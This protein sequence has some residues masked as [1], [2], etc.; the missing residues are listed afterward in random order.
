MIVIFERL[1]DKMHAVLEKEDGST[2]SVLIDKL[3]KDVKIGDCLELSSEGTL[4]LLL[5]ETKKRKNHVKK[6]LD[7][8]W[9]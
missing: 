3:P 9:E 6:L 2:F 1:E 5:E 4:R 7:D 8:L